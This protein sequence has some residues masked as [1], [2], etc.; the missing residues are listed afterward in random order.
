MDR[1]RD[2]HERGTSHVANIVVVAGSKQAEALSQSVSVVHGEMYEQILRAVDL[3]H[4][5]IRAL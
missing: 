2:S 1:Q 3:G 5:L 4:T